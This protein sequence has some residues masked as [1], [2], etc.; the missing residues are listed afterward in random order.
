ML[1]VLLEQETITVQL[2][3]NNN[4]KNMRKNQKILGF[5]MIE[6]LVVATI[7]IVLTTLGLVSY[8][9]ATRNARN[10]KRAA[11]IESIRSALVLYRSDNGSYPNTASF[12]TMVTTLSNNSYYSSPTLEDPKNTGVYTYSYTSDGVTFTTCY[13]QEPDPGTQ[14]CLNNP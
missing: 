13:Y 6:L 4:V 2:T 9:S 8:Q 1:A 7:I 11:D 10:G 5:T 3:F 14:V 12:S